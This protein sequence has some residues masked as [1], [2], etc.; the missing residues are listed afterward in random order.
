MGANPVAFEERP[1]IYI[2]EE[3]NRFARIRWEHQL[4]FNLRTDEL[5]S[6]RPC[7]DCKLRKS[8]S[9]EKTQT[10]NATQVLFTSC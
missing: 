8:H 3:L 10:A 5:V 7:I 9:Q 1:K 6:P 4:L 2:R